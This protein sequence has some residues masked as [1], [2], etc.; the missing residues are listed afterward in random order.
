[1]AQ[2]PQVKK[3]EIIRNEAGEIDIAAIL[4]ANGLS[5]VDMSK[6]KVLNASSASQAQELLK[7]A[8]AGEV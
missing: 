3:A 6:V 5:D 4:A 1:M 2:K 8:N 7:K